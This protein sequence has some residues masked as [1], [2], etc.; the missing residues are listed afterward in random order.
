MSA[1]DIDTSSHAVGQAFRLLENLFQHEVWVAAF[2]YLSEV[3]VNSL[4]CQFLLFAENADDPYFLAEPNLGDVPILQIHHLVGIFND[5]TGITAEEELT[6]ADTHNDGT[7]LASGDNLARVALVDDGNGIG[8]NHLIERHLHSLKQRQTFPDHDILHQLHQHLRVG[9]ALTLNTLCLQ[10]RLDVGI[11]L[12][13][14]VVDDGQVT[15]LRVVRVGIPCR[16]LAVSRPTRMGDAD[17]TCHVLVTAIL[18]QVV[19][20]AFGLIHVQTAAIA[21]HCHTG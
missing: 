16:R 7:L 12:D 19:H 3:Y 17:A 4:D 18:R 13:D 15:A 20:L 6:V 21:N 5:R 10:L 14:A 1:L 11:V 9:V 2:L 8:A